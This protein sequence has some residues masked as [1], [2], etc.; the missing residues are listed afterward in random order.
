MLLLSAF[1]LL[2]FSF[3]SCSLGG[4]DE[5][6]DFTVDESITPDE[7]VKGNLNIRYFKRGFGDQ[8]LYNSIK[9]FETKYPNVKV[10]ATPSTEAKVIYGEIIGGIETKFDL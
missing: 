10:K 6:S 7:S 3:A 9:T 4:S 1:P 2:A 5:G 8:W